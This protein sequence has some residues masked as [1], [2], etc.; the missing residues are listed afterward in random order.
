MSMNGSAGERTEKPSAKKLKDARE[1][2]SVA[3]SADLS[4]AVALI[5][6]TL[7][8]GWFG[9]DIAAA[10]GDRLGAALSSFGNEAR[11]TL[12][13]GRVAN[14]VWADG[15]L[16]ARLVGPLAL[17]AAASSVFA[18]V[19]QVGW[20]YSPKALRLNWG[21]LAPAQGFQKLAPSHSGPELAK[22]VLG[23][24][25]VGAICFYFIRSFYDQV[26]TLVAMTPGEST[27]FGWTRLW[28][29]LWRVTVALALLGAADYLVQYWRWF[30]QQKMTR[31]EVRDES[32]LNEGHP[33]IKQRVRRIQ[34]EMAQKR[35]LHHVKTAT[36]VVTN[37]T[38]FAVA[39][40]YRRSE[41]AAPVV[42]AKGQDAMAARIRALAR[43][44]GVP[45][46]E[47]VTLARAL[48][49]T[50]DVGEAIPASL[51]GAVAEIL[52]YLVRLKQLVL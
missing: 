6:I 9:A 23:I 52:A 24:A 1:R 25:A 17:I 28:G 11:G 38:H 21:R 51:F 8:L 20:G 36:V 3:R 49:K 33:E 50:A 41:M 10:A 7:A 46:V 48:Y 31:Q 37:P 35:M 19:V 12:D 15:T 34:R 2:G 30:G 18:S 16:L 32:K 13:P 44:H 45:I 22:A 39:L 27:T 40:E 47:N 43:E 4:G 29:L 5:G 42:V 26:P 14:I